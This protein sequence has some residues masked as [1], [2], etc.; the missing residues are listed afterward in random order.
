MASVE[1]GS[2][3][4]QEFKGQAFGFDHY[5]AGE[6][7]ADHGEPVAKGWVLVRRE[8]NLVQYERR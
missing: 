5:K 4:G 6:G 3:K 1:I 2:S 8:F 7:E